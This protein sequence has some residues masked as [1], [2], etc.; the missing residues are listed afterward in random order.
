MHANA[1]V[2]SAPNYADI[3]SPMKTLALALLAACGSSD[4]A[5]FDCSRGA[6]NTTAQHGTCKIATMRSACGFVAGIYCGNEADCPPDWALSC[7]GQI[8]SAGSNCTYGPG[9]YAMP[10]PMTCAWDGIEM[11][12]GVAGLAVMTKAG[13][14]TFVPCEP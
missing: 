5:T 10:D 13:V 12:G 11:R 7:Q 9:T 3:V 1:D 4:N 6:P 8:G 14:C 2:T